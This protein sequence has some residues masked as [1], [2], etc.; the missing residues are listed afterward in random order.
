MS[1]AN[2]GGRQTADRERSFLRRWSARKN[3]ARAED[4]ETQN[5]QEPAADERPAGEVSGDDQLQPTDADMPPLESLGEDSDYRGFLSPR[6]SQSLRR[7]ALRKLFQ[8]PRFD[9]RDGLDDYDG[10]YTRYTPLGDTVTAHAKF[11][12]ERLRERVRSAATADESRARTSPNETHES[13][14]REA[15][16]PTGPS[17]I[18]TAPTHPPSKGESPFG[19]DRE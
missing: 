3:Q 2:E 5:P 10:D 17:R 19:D 7:A 6:V 15:D 9:V 13:E 4:A 18:D 14:T 11:H 16:E 1:D 8:S 12:T